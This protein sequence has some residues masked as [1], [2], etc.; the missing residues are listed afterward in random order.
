[1]IMTLHVYIYWYIHPIPCSVPLASIPSSYNADSCISHLTCT[2]LS[3][4]HVIR[5]ASEHTQGKSFAA[6]Q[7]FAQTYMIVLLFDIQRYL[8]RGLPLGLYH[9]LPSTTDLGGS[10][11]TGQIDTSIVQASS[12]QRHNWKNM[13]CW[14][15]KSPFSR[16]RFFVALVRGLEPTS[17][18]DERPFY[19]D[20]DIA[21]LD[22]YIPGV[23]SLRE[24]KYSLIFFVDVLG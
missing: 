3:S 21:H 7:S 11:S 13:G 9:Q 24:R 2:V 1:M 10:S 18:L 23:P 22:S 8:S 12:S 5:P 19:I 20:R 15:Q 16:I 14:R 4:K 17:D 6:H